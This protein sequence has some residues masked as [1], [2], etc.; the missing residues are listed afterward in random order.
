MDPFLRSNTRKFN[1]GFEPNTR[2][3]NPGFEPNT[4]KIP[5]I[6]SNTRKIPVIWSNTRYLV[7]LRTV[8]VPNWLTID[9]SMEPV[10]ASMGHPRVINGSKMTVL[11][12]PWQD[13]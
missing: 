4:R 12:P 9:A 2:K 3:F 11:R 1:P 7:Y 6:W 13:P 10:D 5:V 8:Q